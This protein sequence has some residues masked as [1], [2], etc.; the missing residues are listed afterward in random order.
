MVMRKSESFRISKIYDRNAFF[1]DFMESPME[2]LS[3]HRW[4]K[5]LFSHISGGRVLEVGVG[6]GKNIP[7]Y[8]P[9]I[10][11]V[12]IDFS[13]KMIARARSVVIKDKKDVDLL[14]MDIEHLGFADMT[15]NT[16]LGTF[17]FCSVP[18]PLR[19]LRELRRVCKPDGRLLL[20]EHVRPCGHFT[21]PLFDSINPLAVKV[22]G[23]NINRTTVQTIRKAGFVIEKERNLLS[24]VV[25]F[26]VGRPE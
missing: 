6:T 22:S 5:L 14:V 24:D 3:F 25:K 10:H 9:E 19:G 1:Y 8:P 13:K 20:L 21:G 12:A 18:D 4:R 26:I 15:F 16:I 2:I 11:P 7:F 17:L 23:A